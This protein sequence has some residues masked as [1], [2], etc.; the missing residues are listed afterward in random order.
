MCVSAERIFVYDRVYSEFVSKVAERVREM[1][2]GPPLR[3]QSLLSG[4]THDVDIGPTTMPRQIQILQHLV[5]DA[6]LRGGRVLL[7]GGA[8]E[9]T[10]FFQPT[11]IVDVDRSARI[12]HEEHFG[13][14]MVVIR[15]VAPEGMSIDDAAVEM[16][17]SCRFGLGSS[18]FSSNPE[19]AYR[20]A[21]RIR[22]GMCV[23]NDYGIA[24]MCQS[25]PFGG[26]KMSGM[27]RINGREGLRA[28]CLERSILSDRFSRAGFRIPELFQFPRRNSARAYSTMEQLVE[29]LYSEAIWRR[30][31]AG[32]RLLWTMLRSSKM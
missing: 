3:A 6:I 1:R 16:A 18:V 9:G 7:G 15:V 22:S 25:L 13:P 8:V 30:V 28:C 24:Y 10:Q 27:G 2:Y 14:I 11:L 20:I 32:T 19:R 26:V 29:V 23:I 4:R 21:S 5:D 12:M 31:M 17:N